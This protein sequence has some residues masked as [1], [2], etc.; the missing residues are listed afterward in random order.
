M[1]SSKGTGRSLSIA[2]NID[3][4]THYGGAD[5]PYEAIKVI[6]AWGLDFHL[7]NTVKYISR[8]GKKGDLI[9]DLE[10]AAWYLNRKIEGLKRER[11]GI[12]LKSIS[13]PV[14][15]GKAPRSRIRPSSLVNGRR[16]ER[17]PRGAPVVR[18]PVADR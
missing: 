18:R 16:S 2:P 14:S 12:A 3:H 1:A 13:H 15:G 17:R 11:D 7:G 10:K 4:P 9:E 6:E 5:N 8:A